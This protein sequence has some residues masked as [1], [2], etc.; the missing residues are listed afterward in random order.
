MAPVYA[1]F[2]STPR[3]QELVKRIRG[4]VP[5]KLLPVLE[6]A[7]I[8]RWFDKGILRAVTQLPDVSEEYDELRRFPF[9]KPSRQG[10]RLHDSSATCNLNGGL[11]LL[12]G[13]ALAGCGDCGRASGST[14]STANGTPS[15]RSLSWRAA[16]GTLEV[17]DIYVVDP[18]GVSG[19]PS[20]AVIDS[21]GGDDD[22]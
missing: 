17:T 16:E 10:L 14:W 9:V 12:G 21:G 13:V 15:G 4:G 20:S 7:A 1:K 18:G 11:E 22:V 8:V 5:K 6:A 19:T 2:A 3:L